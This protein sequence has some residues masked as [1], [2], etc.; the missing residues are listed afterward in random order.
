MNVIAVQLDP[1]WHDR[2][3]NHAKVR[4]LLS[5][6]HVPAGSLVVLP[7]MFATGFSMD[8]QAAADADGATEAFL[9]QIAREYDAAV[10]GGLVTRCD[11]GRGR[12]EAVVALPGGQTLLRYQKIHPFTFGGEPRHYVGGR[13]LLLF[14]WQRFKIAPF[15]CY[16]LRFPEVVRTAALRGAQ[17]L[18]IIANWPV[19]REEHWL[20]LL[21]ARAIENQC[22][23]VGVNRRGKDPNVAYGGRTQI[24]GPRGGVIA[25]AGTGEGVLSARLDLQALLD[26]RQEFPVLQ[27]ARPQFLPDVKSRT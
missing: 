13:E 19:A 15:I 22:Y 17:V 6:A 16:D 4:A 18:A 9:A 21:K 3:A 14:D 26:Y 27:D 1:A 7:E 25:D 23:V 2:H 24:L 8:V 11:D 12:N 10:L 5:A 20:A